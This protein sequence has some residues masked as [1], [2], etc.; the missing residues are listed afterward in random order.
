[1]HQELKPFSSQYWSQTFAPFGGDKA[2]GK[3]HLTFFSHFQIF[4]RNSEISLSKSLLLDQ[5]KLLYFSGN[6]TQSQQLN[7]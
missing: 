2:T 6:Q 7:V 1:M 3:L 4:N 5:A